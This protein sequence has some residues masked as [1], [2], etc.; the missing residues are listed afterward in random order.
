[1]SLKQVNNANA[2][3]PYHGGDCVRFRVRI[4]SSTDDSSRFE[5]I[6]Q[7]FQAALFAYLPANRLPVSRIAYSTDDSSRI[8]SNRVDSSKFLT[9]LFAF[10]A[11]LFFSKSPANRL[12][13]SRIVYSTD[14]STRIESNRHYLKRIDSF[15]VYWTT[16]AC[17]KH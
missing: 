7:T 13:V 11:C 3:T 5:S 6:R 1:M 9:A 2:V 10:S 8:E 17:V 15:W 12:P 16:L 4:V 14:D